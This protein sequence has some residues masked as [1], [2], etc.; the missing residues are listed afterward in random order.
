MD[1]GLE[2]K[3]AKDAARVTHDALEDGRKWQR[4]RANIQA[5]AD[6]EMGLSGVLEQGYEW[7][8]EA[9]LRREG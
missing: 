3:V 9:A 4:I 7:T 1:N 6:R 5:I 2:A 8:I